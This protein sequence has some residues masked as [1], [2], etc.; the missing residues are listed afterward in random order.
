MFLTRGCPPGK[1][2]EPALSRSGVTHNRVAKDILLR[3]ERRIRLQR[4]SL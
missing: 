2:H 3:G 1:R 4:G